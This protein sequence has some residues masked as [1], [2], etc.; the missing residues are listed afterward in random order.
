MKPLTLDELDNFEIAMNYVTISAY[1]GSTDLHETLKKLPSQ[2]KRLMK[3]IK[4]IDKSFT[5]DKIQRIVELSGS[6]KPAPAVQRFRKFD[7]FQK[8]VANHINDAHMELTLTLKL[9]YALKHNTA[10]STINLSFN[11]LLHSVE[12]STHNKRQ[13]RIFNK[14]RNI[15]VHT[16]SYIVFTA[17]SA[18][19]MDDFNVVISD[20]A[21]FV[22]DVKMEYKDGLMSLYH[23]INDIMETP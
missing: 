7:T 12:I 18:E 9:L 4:K 11:E 21:Y 10:I 8:E 14:F 17:M 13:L 2:F 23:A 1:A 19:W 22:E 15:L 3:D 20:L 16:N 6:K 5:P